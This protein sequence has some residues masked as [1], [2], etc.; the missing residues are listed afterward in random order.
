VAA[1][2]ADALAGEGSIDDAIRSSQLSERHAADL[3]IATQVMWRV[4]RANATGDVAL[5]QR[6]VELAEP[7]D[8]TDIRARALLAVGDR[9][10][11][12]REYECKGNVAAVARIAAASPPSS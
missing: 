6:A 12:A 7:T 8:F 5:A 1:F 11:A 10:G 3:D 2:L 4:A 9:V